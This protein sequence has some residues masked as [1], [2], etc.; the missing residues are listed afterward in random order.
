VP[1]LFVKRADPA[2]AA[3]ELAASIRETLPTA[4]VTT[5]TLGM[6]QQRSLV[7]AIGHEL[8]SFFRSSEAFIFSVTA[9]SSTP[10]PI[11]IVGHYVPVG[12]G[13]GPSSILYLTRLRHVIPGGVAFQ[14][15]RFRSGE[16]QGDPVVSVALNAVD[17]LGAAVWRLLQPHV[18][19]GSTVVTT[20]PLA[21]LIPDDDGALFGVISA[22]ARKTFGLGGYRL[23]L[24]AFLD[25]TNGIDT[26][27]ARAPGVQPVSV[28][29]VPLPARPED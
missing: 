13:A 9:A 5:R 28:V 4:G 16:F 3:A 1:N 18:V 29:D 20:E 21:A 27:I 12:R 22:P 7:G 17:G 6:P 10:R 19:Y 24:A 26:A 23:D 8:S 2:A 15:G 11:E 14:R 25:L